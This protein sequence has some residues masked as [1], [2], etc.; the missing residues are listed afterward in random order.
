MNSG[1]RWPE[2]EPISQGKRSRNMSKWTT[3]CSSLAEQTRS[4]SEAV[5]ELQAQVETIDAE[6]TCIELELTNVKAERDT[7][8][9]KLAAA[10]TTCKELSDQ[11]EKLQGTS[12]S[13]S[14]TDCQ[15]GPQE[16]T[17]R[18]KCAENQVCDP[19]MRTTGRQTSQQ[20]PCQT[21]SICFTSAGGTVEQLSG[22]R[23][24]SKRSGD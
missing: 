15:S 9:K 12:N 10:H 22:Q 14:V 18:L 4:N 5:K 17:Q 21:K 2:L 16:I 8:V 6:R 1:K 24:N 19:S 3:L 13:T 20:L 11:W 7:L 23:T